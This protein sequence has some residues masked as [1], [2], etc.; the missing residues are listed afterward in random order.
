MLAA[1]EYSQRKRVVRGHVTGQELAWACRDFA[2][3]QFG[4][5]ARSVLRFWGLRSTEDIGRIVFDLIDLGLFM[6]QE[7]DTLDDF[8]G[9]FDFSE[10]FDADYPWAGVRHVGS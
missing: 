9:V 6:K 10:A 5:T 3:E 2:M 1:L 7:S 8:G 4:L